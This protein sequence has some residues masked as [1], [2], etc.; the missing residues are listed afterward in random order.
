MKEI[1][2]KAVIENIT[3]ITMFADEYMEEVNVPMKAMV[4][5]DVAIDEMCSNVCNYAYK[6][7]GEIG[8]ITVRLSV[9]KEEPKAFII[10]FVDEGV[11]YNPL[12]KEDPDVT[13]PIEDRSVGGLG[14]FMVKKSMDDMT[15]EYKDGKNIVTIT[16]RFE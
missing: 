14:I 3:E 12:E 4:A 5:L 10:T 16:K 2:T 11:P 15:Y 8:D 9:R 13:L 1:T 6:E 7:A